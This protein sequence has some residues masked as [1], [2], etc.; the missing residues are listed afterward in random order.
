MNRLQTERLIIRD[1]LPTDIDHWHH[2]MSDPKTMTYLQDIMT[3]SLDESRQN[4]EAAIAAAKS[5]ERVQVFFAMEH[6]ATGVFIGTIGYT[7][8]DLT[9]L[10]KF[11]HVGY[12][13]LPEHHGNGYT[14]EALREILRFAFEEDNVFRINTGCLKENQAS[15]RVMQKC[16]LIKEA[17][18]K[19]FQWH[20]GQMKD[21]VE[22]R[23]LKDEWETM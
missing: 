20:E 15:E 22:Y 14:T 19:A 9:P 16:G 12:F 11:A 5:P 18:R 17:E 21:R 23:L 2:L 3:H 1:P 8:T 7:V 13:I 4:L 10:G 6:R